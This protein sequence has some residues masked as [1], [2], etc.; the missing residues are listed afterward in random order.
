MIVHNWLHCRCNWFLDKY[1]VDST[2]DGLEDE[3]DPVFGVGCES[4]IDGWTIC[5]FVLAFLIEQVEPL[6]GADELNIPLKSMICKTE[7]VLPNDEEACE[8]D[9]DPHC[10]SVQHLR[11]CV[12]REED[13]ETKVSELV[14]IIRCSIVEQECQEENL[15]K[16]QEVEAEFPDGV[17]VFIDYFLGDIGYNWINFLVSKFL[18]FFF[19]QVLYFLFR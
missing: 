12:E 17:G 7:E 9:Q 19:N 4:E 14:Q 15:D 3:N 2:E 16:L 13:H 6:E 10:L 8:Q 1:L 18:S 11:H 5:P